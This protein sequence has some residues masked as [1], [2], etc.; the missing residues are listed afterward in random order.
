MGESTKD[1]SKAVLI[2]R[3]IRSYR[4]D[5][6]S[7][8]RRLSQDGLL[9]LMVE[10]GEEIAEELDHSRVSRWENGERLA[11]RDFLIAFGRSLNVPKPEMDRVL[12]LAG[13][14]MLGDEEAR[15]AML[16][17]AQS[18]ES[19]VERLQRDVRS[20]IDSASPPEPP[21]DAYGVAKDALRRMA[22]PSVYA[23]AV[24]FVLNA[25]GLNG[26]L[27]LMGYVLVALAIVVGQGVV[28]WLKPNR[29]RTEHDHIVD[30][31]FIS[32]FFTMNTSLLIGTLT[33]A[34][35]FGFY[36][37]EAFRNTAM[38]FLATILAHLALSLAASVLFSVLWMRQYGSEGR[39]G[40]FSRAV[41]ITLPPILLAYATF[42]VFTNL[43]VWMYFMVVFGILFAAFT[44]I[45]ALN[46]PGMTLRNMD[47]MLKAAIV[48]IALL[49]SLGVVATI[50]SYLEPDTAI[51]ASEFRI[52][53]LKEISAEE[54]GYTPE[55]G[56]EF[57]RLG[58]LWMSL[59]NILYMTIVVGGYL[60]VTIGRATSLRG[61]SASPQFG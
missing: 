16:A 57:L 10:R 24:G 40:I 60:L 25:L 23:L 22:P 43:G 47:F 7:N 20:L 19:Q 49:C 32:L 3:L 18:I 33:K 17:A 61:A 15:A 37:I 12:S 29:E 58:G 8:G 13:Y 53:P 44:L 34:D 28:R 52:I 30:L 6:R 48:V 46:E 59:A 50:V 1:H 54:L 5:V 56:V 39:G 11:P 41:W 9:D 55:Q 14:E 38:P 4:V 2:G 21:V 36:T 27:A 45:V 35:H 26:T 51:T 42:V 31:F